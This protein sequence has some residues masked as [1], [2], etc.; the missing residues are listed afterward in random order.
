MMMNNSLNVLADSLDMKIDVLK[1]IFDY[2]TKQKS[3]F[4]SEDPDV[5]EFDR[6][7]DEKDVL[8]DKLESLDD[9]FE[10]LYQDVSEQLKTERDK[11]SSQIR[12][13]QEKIR[14]ITDMSAS[15]QAQEARNRKMIEDYFTKSRQGIKQN[16]ASSK[17]AF[18]Y[19]KNMTGMNLQIPGAWD[20][21]N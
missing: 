15:I 4:E 14:E 13:L 7:V 9:G 21:K 16:R 11:Y 6:L 3:I 20:S 5:D 2:T 10:K 19:Y 12:D 8:V 18:D 1:K 17:A